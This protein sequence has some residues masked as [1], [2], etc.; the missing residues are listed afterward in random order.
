MGEMFRFNGFIVRVWSNDHKPP[1]VEAYWPSMKKPEGRAK[2]LLE[3]LECVECR[4]FSKN[5]IKRIQVEL[6]KRHEKLWEGWNE[7]HGKDEEN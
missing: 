3:T 2:F 5:D 6:K 1:H 4:G 7:I